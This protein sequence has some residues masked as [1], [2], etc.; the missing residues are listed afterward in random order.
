[1]ESKAVVN[2]RD[3]EAEH[4]ARDGILPGK[5][6]ELLVL[7]RQAL[8]VTLEERRTNAAAVGVTKVTPLL[9]TVWRMTW[10][11]TRPAERLRAV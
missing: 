3:P 11:R 4:G 5:S 1:M 10:A 6:G 8:D 7:Q 9:R 2:E